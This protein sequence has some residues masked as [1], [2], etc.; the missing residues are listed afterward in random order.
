MDT[1]N[2]KT[3]ANT[4]YDESSL[5]LIKKRYNLEEIK[6]IEKEGIVKLVQELHL[7]DNSVSYFDGFYLNYRIKQI[8]PE[9]DLL[10][11][12]KEGILNIELKSKADE[13]KVLNQ[14]NKSYFY[15]KAVSSELDIITYISNEN[16]FYKY[17]S[18]SESTIKIDTNEVI[19]ILSKY[20][21]IEST[22]LDDVFKPS[23]YLI[24]PFNDTEKFLEQKYIL[25]QHQQN[26]VNNLIKLSNDYI[27]E[28]IAGTGKSLVIYDAANKL[29]KLDRNILIIH[30]G[31]LNDGHCLL[32]KETGWN[33]RS[34]KEG[35]DDE[36]FANLDVILL[37][38][39]QRLYP[40]QLKNI[41]NNAKLNNAKLIFSLDPRQYLSQRE[42][43][44]NNIDSIK[45]IY[46]DIKHEKLTDKIRSNKEIACFIKELFDNDKKNNI[47][48][49]NIEIDY[50]GKQSNFE[51]YLNYLENNSWTYLSLTTSL[52]DAASFNKYSS[53]KPEV[54]SHRVIG[55]EF[56]NVA[57]ILD[58]SFEMK[59]KSLHYNGGKHYYDPVQMVFQNITRTRKKLKFIIVDNMD[60]YKNLMKIVTK[61]Y[62]LK[63]D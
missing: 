48:Y 14:Q 19:E 56:D 29:I 62:S 9:F 59:N 27:V 33:I 50:I 8:N 54:N 16:I 42:G 25:T 15:L 55:Q 4:C 40:H 52:Y 5:E 36:E 11:Y 61:E 47:E 17:D 20:K 41:I 46:I 38:E 49:K 31:Y 34:I 63:I 58:S 3:L 39:V 53:F 57:I 1:I 28:G 21:T 22:H 24:S 2:L 23:N 51:E 30:C 12:T 35:I 6:E 43:N 7:Y 26:I 45:E 10:K 13:T 32:N 60:L 18:T 44:Y 37:D